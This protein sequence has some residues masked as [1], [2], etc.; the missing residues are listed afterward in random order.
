MTTEPTGAADA[1]HAELARRR[2]LGPVVVEEVEP[3]A[4]GP[5]QWY[6]V[7]RWEEV[8]AALSHEA[9]SACLYHDEMGLGR[10]YGEVLLGMDPPAHRHHRAV[11]QP[12][13]SRASVSGR[14]R[15]AV[16]APVD[17]VVD[18]L[19][20][21]RLGAGGRADLLPVLCEPVPV[22]VLT[23]LLGVPDELAPLLADQAV[24]L[25]RGEPD[26]AVEVADELRA[27][28]EPLV[29][30][31]RAARP[32]DDLISVLAHGRVEGR[33]LTDVEVFSHVRLLAIAGT[34]T[35]TRAMG[36]LLAALLTH[37][38]QLAAVR[39][40]PRLVPAAV[41]EAIRWECP[42]VS[43][44]RIARTDLEL[45]GVP[46]PAGSAVRVALGAANR[47]PVRWVD[48]DRY[49]ITR[50]ALPHAGFGIGAHSCLGLHLAHVL[51][52]HVVTTLLERLPGLRLDPE[53]PPPLVVGADL[54]APTHLA[55]R[56]D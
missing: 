18:G 11:L 2:S 27:C 41:E 16:T 36:N 20:E 49:A 23:A 17:A 30:A 12:S 42:A 52:G 39:E 25:G 6:G 51:L 35:V 10:R 56:W 4:E 48:P 50:P 29:S 40:D 24:V 46:I 3:T 31:R 37:P 55:V 19:V 22:R 26:R 34:D 33:L 9:L 53:T 14:L 54:R 38:D 43:V 8:R 15:S 44:P 7:Y 47:D 1:T 21:G 32:G 28:L 13:F 45:A 5:R